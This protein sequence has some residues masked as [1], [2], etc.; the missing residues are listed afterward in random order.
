M[1]VSILELSLAPCC[2]IFGV[3]LRLFLDPCGRVYWRRGNTEARV[4][5][6]KPNET[7]GIFVSQVACASCAVARGLRTI[8]Q[9]ELPRVSSSFLPVGLVSSAGYFLLNNCG[10]RSLGSYQ[11]PMLGLS[12]L[13]TKTMHLPTPNQLLLDLFHMRAHFSIR[14]QLIPKRARI[15]WPITRAGTDA[16]RRVMRRGKRFAFAE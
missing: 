10:P 8:V 12:G 4:R 13:Y 6:S 14:Q 3:P 1:L 2:E 7:Q 11:N 16:S 9:L 5:H 15:P